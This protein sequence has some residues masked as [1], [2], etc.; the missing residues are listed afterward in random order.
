MKQQTDGSEAAV[1]INCK[2]LCLFEILDI[3]SNFKEA[4]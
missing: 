4:K 2:G 3:E 1:N